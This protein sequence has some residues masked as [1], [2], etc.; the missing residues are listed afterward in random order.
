[1]SFVRH[2]CLIDAVLQVIELDFDQLPEGDEVISILK[3]EHTQLHIWIALAVSQWSYHR[4]FNLRIWP[5]CTVLTACTLPFSVG[6][7]Q[8]GQNGGFC[9]AFRGG[10]YWWKPWLQRPWEG[11]DDLSGHIGSLLCPASAQ[12]KKQR[13]QERAHHTGHAALHYGRQDHH[14]WSGKKTVCQNW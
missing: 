1:M 6:V 5:T 10:S 8:A 13:C 3:Q 9:Q 7:L 11:P 14:V 12:R 4:Q 2:W